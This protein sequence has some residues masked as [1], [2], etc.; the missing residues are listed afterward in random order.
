MASHLASPKPAPSPPSASSLSALPR[1]HT[2][3]SH[4]PP[5][6]KYPTPKSSHDA[7]RGDLG[8]RLVKG[9]FFTWVRPTPV[10][11]PEVLA[12]S[13]AALQDLGI[14]PSAVNTE[15]FVQAD[16]QQANGAIYP[17]AQLYGGFQ[18]GSW[19]GQLGDGRAHSLFTVSTPTG[20]YELQLKGSGRTPFS[21][22][23]DGRAVL[24]SSIREFIVSENL[25]ALHIP[26]TRALAL[27]K[28]GKDMKVLRERAEP[29]ALVARFASTWVRLGNFDI[30]R[31]RGDRAAIQT[32]ANYVVEHVLGGWEALDA[33]LPET[34]KTPHSSPD[35]NPDKVYAD[36]TP[37]QLLNPGNGIAASDYQNEGPLLQNR[38]T[39]LYRTIC[40]LNAR[41]VAQWQIYGFTNGVLNTDNTSIAGLSLDF[42]P[43]AF[44]D[45]YD[46]AYTPNH[47][48]HALRYSYQHQ[49]SIV[50]WNLTR[51]GEAL[52]ELIGSG[53]LVDEERYKE[54][55]EESDIE[56][57]QERGQT[58]IVRAGA[59]YR[60]V[61]RAE[62]ERGLAGRLGLKGVESGDFDNVFTPWLDALEAGELDYHL[63]YRRLGAVTMEQ[64]KTEEG[65]KEAAK[66]LFAKTATPSEEVLGQMATWLESW[67]ERIVKDWGEDGDA[68]RK[69]AMDRVNPKFVPRSWIL[70][71]VIQRV[72]R[73]DER[74]ILNRVMN[75]ALHPFQDS[76]GGDKEEEERFC[77]DVP[78]YMA[79][80]QCSCSS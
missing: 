34:D 59:E 4:L 67:R 36:L 22:F 78:K 80:M 68:E 49:P 46:P 10:P 57:V 79:Q 14:D 64:L 66:G 38:Y 20:P 13:P 23:A 21:R 37:T 39:R 17:W 43:F 40:R 45:A 54:G 25:N 76:W 32:L 9:G 19:A 77:G 41:T 60:A 51:L 47:D 15:E 5:D 53:K 12:V 7:P 35:Y 16:S 18:F 63:S 62:Y 72:E 56:E 52:G 6:P 44:L 30:L 26:T 65:R 11:N 2:F 61:L 42:G 69:V 24:R 8:P 28:A 58:L 74:E 3:T 71:E 31:A 75:M 70:D 29:G 27:V 48:D 73:K 1:S 55:L 50:W 33:S